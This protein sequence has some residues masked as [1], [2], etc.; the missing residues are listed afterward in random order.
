MTVHTILEESGVH[1][2]VK[3][4]EIFTSEPDPV[5][6][7]VSPHARV[8][9]L[10]HGH[11][12]LCE[13]G[14]IALYLA[15]I[16]PLLNLL[17]APDDPRHGAFLQWLHYFASTLQPEVMVQFHPESYFS[18]SDE[19]QRFMSASLRRLAKVLRTLDSALASGPYFFGETRTVLD[20]LLV[21]QAIWPEIYPGNI[22]DH[23]NIRR[24]VDT[25]T[26]RPAVQRA[27][28]THESRCNEPIWPL[29]RT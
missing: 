8:P 29:E 21:M 2:T 11:R 22:D 19:Q 9:A 1:Y 6:V 5:F 7:S 3:W 10:R 12:H 17:I 15:E 13:S 26:A 20:Y 28:A 14:A 25:L 24:L 4:V 23:P 27:I 16:F 18:E